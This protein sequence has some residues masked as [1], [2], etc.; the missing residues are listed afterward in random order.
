M[1]ALV[2][3]YRRDR[4][5]GQPFTVYVS[6]EKAT[7]APLLGSWFDRLGV[8]IVVL[9]GYSGQELVTDVAN[10]I[11]MST[12]PAVLIYAGDLD[13]SGEDI[14]RDFTDRVGLF[15]HV[16]RVAVTAEQVVEYDLPPAMG[17]ATDPRA[18]TFRVRHG[19][20]VQVEVEA[21]DPVALSGLYQA[22]I[23]R[24]WDDEAYA[25]VLHQEDDDRGRLAEILDN[26]DDDASSTA[27]RKGRAGVSRP[28]PG[29]A[30]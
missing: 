19:Q 4:T 1:Q 29:P 17:K 25:A 2:G 16:E 18:A 9:R 22:A 26:L 10:D 30:A 5:I 28:V 3:Q 7:L 27:D 8:P 14:L 6:A 20:L 24:Y 11:T 13:P 21:L 23:G 12:G 15:D